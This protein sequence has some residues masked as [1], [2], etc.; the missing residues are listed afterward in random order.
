[1]T[2]SHWPFFQ[3]EFC[4]VEEMGPH[5]N[6]LRCDCVRMG[7]VL[8]LGSLLFGKDGAG[9]ELTMGWAGKV[10]EGWRLQLRCRCLVYIRKRDDPRFLGKQSGHIVSA[11]LKPSV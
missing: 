3:K 11:R 2:Y 6:G 9:S 7:A 1:M 8:V 10:A 5:C 4:R